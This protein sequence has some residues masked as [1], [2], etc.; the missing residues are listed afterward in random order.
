[1]VSI[2]KL[3]LCIVENLRI[4]LV[5]IGGSHDECLYTQF[6]ALASIEAE[7]TFVTT[8]DVYERNAHL[9]P[10][11]HHVYFIKTTGKAYADFKRM[12]E[13]VRYFKH[14]KI[15]K[16]VFNT[17]QGGHVRNIAFLLPKHIQAFGIIHTVR[18]FQGS[19]T[20][21]IIHRAIKKYLVL[22]DDLLKRIETPVGISIGSFYPIDFPQ[23]EQSIEKHKD[24]VWITITGGVEN[25]RKDLSG[26]IQLVEQTPENVQFIFLGKTDPQ[27]EDVIELFKQLDERNLRNRIHIFEGFIDHPTFD[28]YLKQSDFLLP[29]IHPDTPSAEQYVVNQI[30]GAFTLAYSYRI[31]LLMHEAYQQ[32]EDLKLAAFFYTPTSFKKAFEKAIHEKTAKSEQIKQQAK[33][34]SEAQQDIYLRFLETH[35]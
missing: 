17:A 8:K 6:L 25:R 11:I 31:P 19:F 30:S 13:L 22:S 20:Q 35:H 5:E 33:W 12:K 14:Q 9:H 28:A 4:A 23:F 10:F 26:F 7:I 34:Q 15:Q 24:A 18:K 29:L 3:H 16:V 32:E 2:L 27:R 1:M 21:K